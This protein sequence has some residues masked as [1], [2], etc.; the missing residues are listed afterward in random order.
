M[1]GGKFARLNNLCGTLPDK[2]KTTEGTEEHRNQQ[3]RFAPKT[4]P[5][6]LERV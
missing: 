6:E 4:A 5:S 2:N 1:S 3:R